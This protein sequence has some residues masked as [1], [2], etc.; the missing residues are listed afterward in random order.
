MSRRDVYPQQPLSSEPIEAIPIDASLPAANETTFNVNKAFVAYATTNRHSKLS[1]FERGMEPQHRILDSVVF[2]MD[3]K[4]RALAGDPDCDNFD[5]SKLPELE[6]EFDRYTQAAKYFLFR[7]FYPHQQQWYA[8][9]AAPQRSQK[10]RM[11]HGGD[12]RRGDA[13]DKALRTFNV[14][15][16]CS[17]GN[18]QAVFFAG[19]H[20]KRDSEREITKK[21]TASTISPTKYRRNDT[22]EESSS[23]AV[24]SRKKTNLEVTNRNRRPEAVVTIPVEPNAGNST[25][26]AEL[27]KDESRVHSAPSTDVA[28]PAVPLYN[29]QGLH[30]AGDLDC[31]VVGQF[32]HKRLDDV[33]A[34]HNYLW[35]SLLRCAFA[36]ADPLVH[37]VPVA[38]DQP[39]HNVPVADEQSSDS[40]P[41]VD[42]ETPFGCNCARCSRCL[43]WT[44]KQIAETCLLQEDRDKRKNP[45]DS[46]DESPDSVEK[47]HRADNA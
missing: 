21:Q 44:A 24:S 39:S 20:P 2:D 47:R 4:L 17:V 16:P 40:V 28:V 11:L 18:E 26:S 10:V 37:D 15:A 12:R 31:D 33:L 27:D 42:A 35:T 25:S 14:Q 3:S 46:S 32:E 6:A 38:D 8:N 1:P 19:T 22:G 7:C 41:A 34:D 13:I 29:Q 43:R 5:I 23:D 9:F 45:D 36:A 30:I